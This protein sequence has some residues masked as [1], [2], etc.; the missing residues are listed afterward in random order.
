MV[1]EG[2][3]WPRNRCSVLDRVVQF[4]PVRIPGLL[5]LGEAGPFCF[6][7]LRLRRTGFTT[8]QEAPWLARRDVNVHPSV[9]A[10]FEKLVHPMLFLFGLPQKRPRLF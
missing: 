10:L 1:P 9:F 8:R 6:G 4:W 5:L 2:L 3:R 7:G